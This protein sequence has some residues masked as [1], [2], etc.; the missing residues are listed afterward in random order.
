FINPRKLGTIFAFELSTA[1]HGYL[2]S[3]STTITNLALT[4]GIF[5]RPLGNTVYIMPPYCINNAELCRVFDF[6]R[7][8][9][10]L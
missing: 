9:K 4:K 7:I 2:N 3:I 1:N 6:L 10:D 5:L 8:L